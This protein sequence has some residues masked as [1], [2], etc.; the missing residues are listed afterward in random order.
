MQRLNRWFV[1]RAGVG[2]YARKPVPDH[3]HGGPVRNGMAARAGWLD[4]AP[5]R[6]AAPT[7]MAHFIPPVSD[8]SPARASTGLGL[9]REHGRYSATQ[10]PNMPCVSVAH[11]E[12]AGRFPEAASPV[13]ACLSWPHCALTCG[14]TLVCLSVADHS[15]RIA[16]RVK[17]S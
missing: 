3:S 2:R 10:H 16:A 9:E 12:T 13:S 7:D 1:V 11:W 17:A 14:T 4:N 5:A 8:P 6:Y 15:K